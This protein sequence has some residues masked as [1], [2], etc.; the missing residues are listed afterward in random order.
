MN[1]ADIFDTYIIHRQDRGNGG[2][3]A[4][5]IYYIAVK[6]ERLFKRT[7]GSVAEGV[8][9]IPGLSE[10]FIE[11]L[12]VFLIYQIFCLYDLTDI[13]IQNFGNIFRIFQTDLLPH[14][15]RRR[16]DPVMSLN[17]PAAIVFICS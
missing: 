15:G 14:M 17:P 5:L 10:H 9:V 2:D 12:A 13:L 16:G 8:P 6:S 1:N 4:C 7:A 3:S 11:S